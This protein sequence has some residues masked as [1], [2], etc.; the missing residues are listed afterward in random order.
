MFV[1]LAA[2]LRCLG[3]AFFALIPFRCI[4]IAQSNPPQAPAQNS[5][6]QPAP[7]RT[8]VTVNATISTETPSSITVLDQETLQETP[9]INLDDRLR[10]VPGFSLFRRSSSIV[11]NPTTQGVSLRGIGSSGAS[12]TLVLSD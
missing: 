6:S 8:T 4:A 5:G 2:N 9:G 7:L 11:A 10:Q 12:R 1:P 3:S